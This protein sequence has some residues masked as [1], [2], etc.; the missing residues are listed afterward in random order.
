MFNK[1]SENGQAIILIALA[2]VVVL[3]FAAMA[4]DLGNVFTE[5]REAQNAADAAALAGAQQIALECAKATGA[6]QA[7]VRPAMQEMVELNAPGAEWVA[8]Y[9]LEDGTVANYMVG[10]DPNGLACG[11]PRRYVGVDVIVT[12][13]TSGFLSGIIGQGALAAKAKARARYGTVSA[14]N[15]GV[16]PITVRYQ[17]ALTYDQQT[18]LRDLGD[19]HAAGN[20]G[21][22][23]WPL[24][25]G[26]G[27]PQLATSLTPPGDSWRYQN[28][29][30]PE[31]NWADAN[32][33]DHLMATGKWVR[34]E[35]GNVNSNAVRNALKYLI[36]NNVTII[37][38][39]YD[40]YEGTGNNTK[41]RI[42][43]FG[44][45][46]LECQHISS[47]NSA[48]G[49][50]LYAANHDSNDK[51]L[52]GKFKGWVI[53][54]GTWGSVACGSDTGVWSVKLISVP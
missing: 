44:A 28:P 33:N 37:I 21:W 16:Y 3:A 27:A 17:G 13:H 8:Y 50:C 10:N 43:A 6:N 31:S 9:L 19:D 15:T 18:E 32:P 38:P 2:L 24:A 51:W 23:T 42:A 49:N 7:N 29:G 47:D 12:G 45:F 22:L 36:D 34:G 30:T 39:L 46:E 40:T 53:P 25:N 35:T 48:Y 26:G 4:I 11:C 41:F 1:K 20:F 52:E 54:T 14:F 5:R